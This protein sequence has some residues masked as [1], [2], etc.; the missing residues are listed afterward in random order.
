MF[1]LQKIAT[2]S[3]LVSGLALV[4]VGAGH[5]YADANPGGCKTT[6]QGGT[7]CIRQS[8][9][10]TD[11]DDT[12]TLKQEQNCSTADR[13]RVMFSEDELT[14]GGSTSVGQAVDCS[15]R[16]ELPKGFKKPQIEL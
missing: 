12:H 13:P 11:E 10:R 8:E 14:G 3:G 15:N 16:A 6:A 2:V 7:V 5:A 1:S 4:C 9:T